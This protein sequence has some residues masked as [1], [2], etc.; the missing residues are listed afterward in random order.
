VT[1]DPGWALSGGGAFDNWNGA[2]NMLTASY[3]SGISW[4]GS[5]KDHIESSPAAITAY[6]IGLREV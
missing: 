3:P 4:I 1:L 6:V 2:G 5:G